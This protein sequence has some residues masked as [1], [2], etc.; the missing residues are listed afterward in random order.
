[1]RMPLATFCPLAVYDDVQRYS[2]V[3]EPFPFIFFAWVNV[4]CLY[5]S[6]TKSLACE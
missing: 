5:S 1:M 3:P 6:N 2:T 4:R